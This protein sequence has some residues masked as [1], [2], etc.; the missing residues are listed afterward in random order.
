MPAARRCTGEIIHSDHIGQA[1]S[2]LLEALS[3]VDEQDVP[4]ELGARL[5]GVIDDLE[6][7]R[8][9]TARKPGQGG[10]CLE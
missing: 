5:Q 2:M 4:P 6:E 7:Y 9:T 3:L 10:G 1:I 8:S